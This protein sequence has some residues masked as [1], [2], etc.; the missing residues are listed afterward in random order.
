VR[1]KPSLK[2]AEN[3]LSLLFQGETAVVVHNADNA[4]LPICRQRMFMQSPLG[5]QLLPL[6]PCQIA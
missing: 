3:H 2:T 5:L 1:R 6:L 4:I